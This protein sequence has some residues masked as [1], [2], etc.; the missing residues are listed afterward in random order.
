MV[1]GTPGADTFF[2]TPQNDSF[3]GFDGDD[4][5]IGSSGN[6]FFDG[7][8]GF[9]TADYSGLTEQIV[10]EPTG[11][12]DKGSLGRDQL[13]KVQRIIGSQN[14]NIIDA[15]TSGGSVSL[16]VNLARETLTVRN[17][18]GIGSLNLSVDNFN[19]VIGTQNGDRIVGGADSDLLR[20]LAGNDTILGG[21]TGDILIGQGGNDVVNG[22]AGGDRLLGTDV[23]TRGQGEIDNVTGGTGND[24][25][26]LGNRDGTFYNFNGDSDFARILDFGTGDRFELGINQ[27]YRAERTSTGFKLFVIQNGTRDLVAN[28]TTTASINLPSANFTITATQGN[29]VFLPSNSF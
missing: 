11:A 27:T 24:R 13:F 16:D 4:R 29:G 1:N 25:F 14:F 6:D 17:V 21:G 12:I 18:P 28:V 8:A 23:D 22:Q 10:L 26:V 19:W 15:S 20:G 5:L 9:N 3:F 2:S 7:G